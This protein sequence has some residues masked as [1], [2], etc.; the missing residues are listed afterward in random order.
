MTT[1]RAATS[2]GGI[3]RR[4]EQSR[5]RLLYESTIKG[6]FLLP[7]NFHCCIHEWNSLDSGYSVCRVCG[8]E[9]W[10][11]CGECPEVVSDKSER[12]CTITGCVTLEYE[13]HPERSALERVGPPTTQT[14]TTTNHNKSKYSMDAIQ[15]TSTTKSAI[16]TAR[17]YMTRR[18]MMKYNG[19]E[20]EKKLYHNINIISDHHTTTASKKQQRNDGT[21]TAHNNTVQRWLYHP[22]HYRNVGNNNNNIKNIKL[23]N[24]NN[25][26]NNNDNNNN[27]NNENTSDY[28]HYYYHHLSHRQPERHFLQ[29]NYYY[30]WQ[31]KGE[32]LRDT[33]EAT[34]RELLDS[35]CTERCL[36]QERKRNEAKELAIF[37]RVLREASHD[38]RCLRPNMLSILAQVVFHCRK[39]RSLTSRESVD[40]ETVVSQCT[41]SISGLLLVYG[42]PRVARQMQNTMRYREF[43]CSMLYLMRVGVTFQ[44]RQILPRMELLNLLLP[45]QVLLPIVFKIR[46]KSIT[47]G[48]NMVFFIFIFVYCDNTVIL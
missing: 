1:L 7:Y 26:N 42:G 40:M 22:Y 43:I 13:M 46:A 23:K 41:D 35:E 11:C 10:C 37:S 45:L 27:N 47:E 16:T 2:C 14:V 3:Q 39:N 31:Q 36:E 15:L 5:L 34:V 30:Y 19:E 48:E 18:R 29:H 4:T 28:C 33:V 9:H 21:A 8:A 17:K 32:Y 12:V 38:K 20:R 24:V 6:G 44:Q 25:N